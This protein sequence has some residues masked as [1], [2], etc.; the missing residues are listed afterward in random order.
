M[1]FFHRLNKAYEY[2]KD[3]SNNK[4]LHLKKRGSTYSLKEKQAYAKL[5]KKGCIQL[6]LGKENLSY[7][8][9]SIV[10]TSYSRRVSPV[11]ECHCQ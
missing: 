2:V 4:S 9:T 7:G 3:V 6:C 11:S 5:I 10:A 8:L 1:S